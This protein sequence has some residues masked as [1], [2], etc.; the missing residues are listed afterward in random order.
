M[1]PSPESPSSGAELV[2]AGVALGVEAAFLEVSRQVAAELASGS[3]DT[4][5]E[6][7]PRLLDEFLA[8]FR[9]E[10]RAVSPGVDT[11]PFASGVTLAL[12]SWR[13][14][15]ATSTRTGSALAVYLDMAM[16]ATSAVRERLKALGL[17]VAPL[18]RLM[19]NLEATLERADE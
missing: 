17:D 8:R 3:A 13:G 11:E 2:R 7:A 5:R 18:D 9:D 1:I 15:I 16:T 14:A 6:S 10:V 19:L 4:V 12:E